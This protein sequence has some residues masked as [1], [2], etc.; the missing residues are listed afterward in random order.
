MTHAYDKND[1]LL[2]NYQK[3]Q[4]EESLNSTNSTYSHN[5]AKLYS[6][7]TSILLSCEEQQ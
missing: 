3:L 4:N 7:K 5:R 2:T 6:T 1:A